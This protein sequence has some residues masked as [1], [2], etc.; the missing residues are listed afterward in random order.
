M[1]EYLVKAFAEDGYVTR[2]I[3]AKDEDEACALFV[4]AVMMKTEN[5]DIEFDDFAWKDLG[6]APVF[7]SADPNN[8]NSD[9]VSDNLATITVGELI[10]E[11]SKF[12][13]DAKVY[14]KNENEVWN[15]FR[16][17]SLCDIEEAEFYD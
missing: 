13:S 11:L 1:R 14:L 5:Y 4:D 17:L 6:P 10:K 7:I 16:G 3:I 15:I 9:F 2:K 8:D 12:D